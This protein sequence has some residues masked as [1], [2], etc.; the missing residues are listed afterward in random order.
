MK[1]A[2]IHHYIIGRYSDK[3]GAGNCGKRAKGSSLSLNDTIF[4]FLVLFV[5]FL[6]SFFIFLLELS[7]SN[8]MKI[9][10]DEGDVIKT[11]AW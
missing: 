10:D 1:D 5:G 9:S 3:A 2:G 4:F 6:L 11:V 7:W 8:C